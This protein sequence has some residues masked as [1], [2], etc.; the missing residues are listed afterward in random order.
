MRAIYGQEGETWLAALPHWLSHFAEKWHFKLERP[1]PQLSYNYVAFVTLAEGTPAVFKMG[2]PNREIFT[3]IETLA[4]YDGVGMVKMLAVE[5][6]QAAFLLQRV[7][8]G[9]ELTAVSDDVATHIIADTLTHL[10]RSPPETHSF[11][12]LNDWLTAFSR[13]KVDFADGPLPLLLVEKAEQISQM[14]LGS[15]DEVLL[16]GDLHHYNVLEGENGRWVTIDPKGVVGDCVFESARFL[17]NPYP[18]VLREPNLE[19][20]IERRVNI[21]CERLGYDRQQVLGWGF[22][23]TMLS[24]VWSVE[25]NDPA[26]FEL[27]LNFARVIGGMS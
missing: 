18:G 3:E 2:V 22:V 16:H 26:D 23:D 7:L 24:L 10:R 27:M 4:L 15:S 8:P 1:V 21:V 9:H 20:L 11:P 5:Q 19:R 17:H 12:H 13:Y 14:L 6:E 25:D